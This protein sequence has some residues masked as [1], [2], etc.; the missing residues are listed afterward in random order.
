MF[1]SVLFT[2]DCKQAADNNNN[3][4]C[5]QSYLRCTPSSEFNNRSA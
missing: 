3:K 1:F 4:N 2:F 5:K